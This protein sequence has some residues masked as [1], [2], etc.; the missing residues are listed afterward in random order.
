MNDLSL[1]YHLL[2]EEIDIAIQEVLQSGR[3]IGGP[4]VEKF[5]KDWASFLGSKHVISCAN[6]TDALQIALMAL[7]LKAGEE[8]IIPA[9]GY[10]AVAEVALLLG[11]KPVIVDVG[12]DYNINPDL[13]KAAI[14][15]KTR[16]IAP[17][18]L[19]GHCA[20]M[21]AIMNIADQHG[22][23]VIED[24]AQAAG[25]SV[26]LGSELKKAGTIGTIGTYSHF[27]TKNLA[28]YGD[29]GSI[30]TSDQKL[31]DKIIKIKVH[32]QNKKYHHE[33]IGINS[34]LDALQAAI[35][36]IKLKHLDTFN[37][38]RKEVASW[39][40]AGLGDNDSIKLQPVS[41]HHVYH[42]FAIQIDEKFRTRLIKR[43]SEKNIAST[44][45]YPKAFSQQR[46]L[47]GNIRVHS[48][49]MA[50][51]LT[52]TTLCLPISNTI[53]KEEIEYICAVINQV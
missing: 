52:K 49:E 15:E 43:L 10:I 24:A 30:C 29:G 34:R 17:I 46:A 31:A 33:I 27:P 9:Y 5:E 20:D 32:G 51:S 53:R 13:I 12:E 23:Y 25:A 19:F 35:L 36:N 4:E 37:Q 14:T 40:Q 47:Q 48:D 7:D 1:E 22:L 42:Q 11:L 26:P 6:G 2:K 44:I 38:Y 28:C 39:Y 16:A 41:T 3:F 8:I 18:H 50:R 45:Y 21:M